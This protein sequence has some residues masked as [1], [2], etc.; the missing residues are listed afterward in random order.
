MSTYAMTDIHGCYDE[1]MEMLDKIKF[2]SDDRLVI[3]GDYVDRGNQSYEMLE[4]ILSPPENVTL[5]K[6]NHDIEFAAYVKY[7]EQIEGQLVSKIES[8]IESKI[9]D[10]NPEHTI[11]LID[12]AEHLAPEL[13]FYFDY[14]GTI[15]R[16]A[17]E[18]NITMTQLKQWAK[19]LINL[20]YL[21]EEDI[22]G[23]HFIVVHAGYIEDA[24]LKKYLKAN[25]IRRSSVEDFYIYAR[26]EAF[27]VGGKKDSIIVAGHTPTIASGRYTYTGGTICK[28]YNEE[29]NCTYYDIDCGAVFKVLGVGDGNMA[30]LRLDDEKEFYLF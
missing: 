23:K 4:W 11:R 24:K 21:F 7:L 18:H 25:S 22:N 16:L 8:K 3:A 27:E 5:L 9:S 14:Y 12:I 28:L 1:L 30:C 26:E 15:H 20:P 6:G 19:A 17:L 13:E 10:D 2:S 29:I